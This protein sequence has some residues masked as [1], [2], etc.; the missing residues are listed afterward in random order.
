M[1]AKYGRCRMN[2][3]CTVCLANFVCL[4]AKELWLTS[5][6]L[7]KESDFCMAFVL[8]IGRP[9]WEPSHELCLIL[10]HLDSIFI[11]G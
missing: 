11:S 6:F 4:P 10:P 5:F 9:T 3:V 8:A 7:K 1:C 2:D